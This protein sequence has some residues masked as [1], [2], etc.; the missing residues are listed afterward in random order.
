[1]ASIRRQKSGA[2]R[3]QARRKGRS[4]S[5]TFVSH[6]DAKRWPIDAERQIDHG[7]TPT[8]SRIARLRTFG[9]LI[10]LHIAEVRDRDRHAPGALRL[11]TSAQLLAAEGYGVLVPGLRMAPE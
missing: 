10:D 5:G 6:D 1:M 2:W 3:V 4:L 7:Q 11:H 9:D 8:R